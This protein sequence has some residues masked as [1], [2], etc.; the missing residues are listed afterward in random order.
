MKMN[1]VAEKHEGGAMIFVDHF[2]NVPITGELFNTY[3]KSCRAKH[4]RPTRQSKRKAIEK[5]ETLI[6]A[7]SEYAWL[8]SKEM[9]K[10]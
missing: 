8:T 2:G 10:P 5:L 9:P 6:S 3:E 4:G 7:W 1:L